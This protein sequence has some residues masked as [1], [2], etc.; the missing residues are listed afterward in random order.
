MLSAGGR[1]AQPAEL[2][3]IS[4]KD[5]QY[6]HEWVEL[7]F[8]EISQK[9]LGPRLW[10]QYSN[11]ISILSR[12]FYFGVTT[13]TNRQSPGEEI[14]GAKLVEAN[15]KE[16]RLLSKI[17]MLLFGIDLGFYNLPGYIEQFLKDSQ[18][19][20]FFFFGDFYE[21]AKRLT[22]LSYIMKSSNLSESAKKYSIVYRVIGLFTLVKLYLSLFKTRKVN[23]RSQSIINE[24][25]NSDGLSSNKLCLLCSETRKDA[26]S[27]ICGHIFCW[28]CI[29]EWL[30]Q[31]PQ[32]PVCRQAT[33]P[34]RLIFLINYV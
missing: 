25:D 20:T 1:I 18:L 8:Q 29:N 21:T 14:Y 22:D 11:S 17:A 7:P 5:S 33:E 19:L 30:K 15:L 9:I 26:T 12:M 6:Y 4:N 3:S 10:I 31:N 32:C 13:L 2:A 24:L 23:E 34:S 27:T 16:P 28:S